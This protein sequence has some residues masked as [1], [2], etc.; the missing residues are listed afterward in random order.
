MLL[1]HD[2]WSDLGLL[3]IEKTRFLVLAGK[4]QG[5]YDGYP[6]EREGHPVRVGERVRGLG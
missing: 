2:N 3:V 5:R 6:D 1:A 4:E